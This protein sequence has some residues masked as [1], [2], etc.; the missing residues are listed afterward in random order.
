[1]NG[2][3]S[4]MLMDIL[5]TLLGFVSIMLILSLIVTMLVQ[6]LQSLFRIRTR[7]LK[8]GLEAVFEGLDIPE[9]DR[10]ETIA[11]LLAPPM[12]KIG[13]WAKMTTLTPT[14]TWLSSEDFQTRLKQCDKVIEAVRPEVMKTFESID[15]YLSKRF[16]M[17]SRFF[18]FGCAALVAITLQVSAIDVLRDLSTNPQLGNQYADVLM[19]TVETRLAS[20]NSHD[21]ITKKVLDSLKTDHPTYA[22]T[23]GKVTKTGADR[24]A[25]RQELHDS[26]TVAFPD[27]TTQCKV[28]TDRYDNLL[29]SLQVANV[30]AAVGQLREINAEMATFNLSYWANGIDYYKDFKNIFGVLL[31]IIL[32]SMGAPFWFKILREAVALRDFLSPPDKEE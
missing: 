11:K 23:I 9:G 28:I 3:D 20:V 32:L 5:G 15:G 12:K 22:A 25:L 26:L 1:M 7:N 29:D 24:N 16:L 19:K 8:H 27:S 21:L 18:S 10:N 13:L 30:S 6:F 31:T 17:I 2:G 14:I 4:N